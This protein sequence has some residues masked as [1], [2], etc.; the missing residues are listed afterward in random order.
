MQAMRKACELHA[1]NLLCM[2]KSQTTRQDFAQTIPRNPGGNK[3]KAYCP[4]CRSEHPFT[5]AEVNGIRY[6][7]CRNC[8]KAY[9]PAE[10]FDAICEGC[11]KYHPQGY[12]CHEDL[13]LSFDL[14]ACMDE[15]RE[16]IGRANYPN[17]VCIFLIYNTLT[18][19]I[20]DYRVGY[21]PNKPKGIF[22][23]CIKIIKIKNLTSTYAL[24]DL[25]GRFVQ[26]IRNSY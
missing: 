8:G 5:P 17:E 2:Q 25:L 10:L 24:Q 16:E 22:P 1:Y 21:T 23:E 14:R 3:M 12:I 6:N 26:G 7:I 19:S 15:L 9:K 4:N 18:Y 13:H 20:E 11:G